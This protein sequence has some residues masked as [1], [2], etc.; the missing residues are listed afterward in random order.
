MHIFEDKIRFKRV[1][2]Y[3]HKRLHLFLHIA[4]YNNEL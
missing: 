3:T 1:H 4:I 2:T